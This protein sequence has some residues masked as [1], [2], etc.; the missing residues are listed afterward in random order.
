[1]KT[2][3]RK[4]SALALTLVPLLL[5][6]QVP[7]YDWQP[8]ARDPVS[9]E[10]FRWYNKTPDSF[11]LHPALQHQKF[12][13]IENDVDVGYFI[14]LPENYLQPDFATHRYPVLYMLHDG[15][16]GNEHKALNRFDAL[17]DKIRQGTL[18]ETLIVF[19]NGGRLPYY[20]QGG[21]YGEQAI[22]ELTKHIDK[23][24]RSVPNR[25]GRTL[26]GFG[27]GARAS[28][29]YIFKHPELFSGAIAAHPGLQWEH[30]VSK[31]QGSETE[32]ITIEDPLDN[33]WDLAFSY[34]ARQHALKIQLAI[35]VTENTQA[36]PST[37][38]FHDYLNQLSVAHEFY[39]LAPG[40]L[41]AGQSIAQEGEN[42]MVN[43]ALDQFLRQQLLMSRAGK[44][45]D[46]EIGSV[47]P[48]S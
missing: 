18:P 16:P 2:L 12:R 24:Y 38:A 9:L 8:E 1:M 35:A 41:S 15:R 11:E 17:Y 36:F 47:I 40:E 14:Y 4:L 23:Q 26:F 10:R 13:S 5:H 39:V 34:T 32:G 28:L 21:D 7:D 44:R 6:A 31:Q 30:Q 42:P 29:R 43:N 20:D 48:A 45:L 22:L 33:A 27:D 19:T 46:A 37:L 3:Y 25:V